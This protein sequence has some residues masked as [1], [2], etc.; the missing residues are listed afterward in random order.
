MESPTLAILAHHKCATRFTRIYLERFCELNGLTLFSSHHGEAVPSAH[1]HISHLTNADYGS[2]KGSCSG[3]ALH[4]V[5]N[6]LSIVVSAYYSHRNSHPLDGW[7]ELAEQRSLLLACSK[8][9]GLWATLHFLESAG[10]YGNTAGPLRSLGNWD[11]DDGTFQTLRME[12]LVNDVNSQLGIHLARIAGPDTQMPPR[13]EFQFSAFAGGRHTGHQ[14]DFS[15]FRSGDP[16]N[17]RTEL[18]TDLI[19]RVRANYAHLLERYYPE[20]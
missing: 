17:W 20:A 16:D 18:P 13:S 8:E 4:I 5:R 2:L 14:D 1:H 10:F 11:F 7:P 3:G 19:C 12:D 9:E 15:H 6:P